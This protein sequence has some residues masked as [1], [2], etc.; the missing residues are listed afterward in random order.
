[1]ANLRADPFF[2]AS[3]NDANGDGFNTYYPG[4]HSRMY[5][6]FGVQAGIY[7]RTDNCWHFGAS[8]KSPQWFETFEFNSSDELG[9]PHTP[10]FRFDYPL[11]ASI[12]LGYTGL[13]RWTFACDF[14]FIDYHNTAGFSQTGFD[15][16]GAVRGLG[17]DSVFAVAAGA[18]YQWTDC[19]SLRLGYSYNTNPI[20]S[21]NTMFNVASPLILQHT[22]YMGGSYNLTGNFL[23]SVAYAHAFENSVEGQIVTPLG[24]IPTSSVQSKVSA[25]T[26]MFGATVKF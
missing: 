15:E 10:K 3:P 26:W 14:R 11:M 13:D 20:D 22:V 19:V 2:V 17:W 16:S 1:M 23:V 21:G 8:I 9:Q 25:D 5:W 24:A 7:Y 18:Q 12:G 4:T 6:G